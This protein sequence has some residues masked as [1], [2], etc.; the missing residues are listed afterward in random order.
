MGY[1]YMKKCSVCGS[2]IGDTDLTCPTC[3]SKNTDLVTSDLA[4][5]PFAK[6]TLTTATSDEMGFMMIVD[7][8]FL[9]GMVLLALFF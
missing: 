3:R 8:A 6:S 2:P 1:F 9:V 7:G 4:F 5:Y